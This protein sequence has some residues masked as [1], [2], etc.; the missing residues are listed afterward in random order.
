[1]TTNNEH[2]R[3]TLARLVFNDDDRIDLVDAVRNND[4]ETIEAITDDPAIIE[5]ARAIVAIE[6][7]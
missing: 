4:T 7:N 6:S 2:P 3:T 5:A 1:M